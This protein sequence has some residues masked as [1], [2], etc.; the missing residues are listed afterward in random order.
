MMSPRVG[1]AAP[2]PFA[3][4]TPDPLTSGYFTMACGSRVAAGPEASFFLAPDQPIDPS[5]ARVELA[6]RVWSALRGQPLTDAQLVAP[7]F[8]IGLRQGRATPYDV[9]IGELGKRLS[10]A[11]LNCEVIGN[12]DTPESLQREAA[13]FTALPDGRVLHAAMDSELTLRDPLFPFGVRAS[14]NA[15]VRRAS[16]AMKRSSFVVVE[17]GDTARFQRYQDNVVPA[18]RQQMQDRVFAQADRIVEGILQNLPRDYRLLVASPGQTVDPETL[19]S[20]RLPLLISFRAGQRPGLLS[21][22]STRRAGVVANTDVATGILN[23]LGVPGSIGSGGEIH[24]VAVTQPLQRLREIQ[25]FARY[26]ESAQPVVYGFVYGSLACLIAL[27]AMVFLVGAP[28]QTRALVLAPPVSFA[29]FLLATSWRP[30]P[31]ALAAVALAA[32]AVVALLFTVKW[33]WPT[34]ALAAGILVLGTVAFVAGWFPIA[35]ASY[36]IQGGARYYGIGNEYAGLFIGAV[37]FL[38]SSPSIRRFWL[39]VAAL[40]AAVCAVFLIGLPRGGANAGD[41]LGGLIGCCAIAASLFH[42]NSRKIFPVLVTG[43]VLLLLLLAGRDAM[44]PPEMQSHL[45]RAMT[46]IVRSGPVAALNIVQ[47]KAELNF[48]LVRNSPWA[49]LLLAEFAVAFFLSR[50]SRYLARVRTHNR[51]VALAVTVVALLAL[52]DSGV[53]SAA[54]AGMWLV[55][56]ALERSPRAKFAPI[57]SQIAKAS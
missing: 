35:A 48:L 52:N 41:M 42:K 30:D 46:E 16:E 13:L 11:R 18:A 56:D 43:A 6:G 4:V 51:T 36:Q 5:G 14:E 34:E 39:R 10:S 2:L 7:F 47:R 22:S 53:L 54:A 19:A 40:A 20:E 32:G 8:E 38:G 31:L 50:R 12:A 55:I 45:G 26:Q 1:R 23:W 15:L 28:I 49:L 57:L 17:T 3:R 27:V 29:S 33:Q 9:P 21:S 25:V 37:I 44:R 24:A